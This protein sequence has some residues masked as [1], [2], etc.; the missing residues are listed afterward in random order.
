VPIRGERASRKHKI[1]NF[2][3]ITCVDWDEG[4]ERTQIAAFISSLVDYILQ[5]ESSKVIEVTILP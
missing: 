3:L 2:P 5:G 1:L 4:S